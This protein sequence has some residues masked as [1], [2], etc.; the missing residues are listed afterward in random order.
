[1]LGRIVLASSLIVLLVS[2]AVSQKEARNDK[3]DQLF[4][5]WDKPMSPGCA[6]G[7]IRDGELIYERG[8][9]M[10]DLEHNI[11]LTSESVFYIASMSKQF[12]AA[13]IA[14]LAQ[15]GK[16]SLDDDIRKYLPEM[17]EYQRPVLIRNLI[18]HTSGIR[19]YIVLK[20][21]AAV[22][23][24]SVNSDDENYER[25]TLI[26]S[27]DV[28]KLIAR[29]R[30][31]SFLPGDESAYSNSN[32]FLLAQIVERVSGKTLPEFADENIFKPLG[33]F[34]THYY[35]DLFTVVENRSIGYSPSQSGAF[36]PVRLNNG[37]VGPAG[38]LTS[39]DDLL[40]WDRNFY[41]NKLG[42]RQ[43][44][45]DL[46]L[47]GDTLNDGTKLQYAFGLYNYKYKGLTAVGHDGG[48]FG[49]KTSM[50]RFTEQR[51]TVICLCNSRNAPMDV[52]A[53]QVTDIYLANEFKNSDTP[54]P[55][56]APENLIT[57]SDREL[58]NFSGIYWNPITEGLW[59]LRVK[60]GKLVDP[61]GGGSIL[62]PIGSNR[63]R[64]QGQSVELNFETVKP[65]ARPTR[66]V[67][68]T[69][70]G[71]PQEYSAVEPVT[72]SVEQLGE[73][74]GRYRS[75]ELDSTYTLGIQ[76]GK[77]VLLRDKANAIPFTP[78]F[79]DNFWSDEFG[80]LRF[81]RDKLRKVNGFLLTGGWI[82]RLSFARI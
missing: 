58:Q 59:M 3:V 14:L 26:T 79:V 20:Y 16:L 4:R 11:P 53:D 76:R 41:N 55:V 46:L 62:I 36:V 49:F 61:G 27:G 22:P 31:S 28:F 69:K 67:K 34:H 64:V 30:G 17:P 25:M 43:A 5:E 66:M 60:D 19:D 13:S 82:R 73:Y 63:F 1:M 35:E 57:L 42:V 44:F 68:I 8:Y 47:T 37:T 18:H 75:E 2:S 21:L 77:L 32:Y 80:Y 50:N 54:A 7:V 40:L 6:L 23:T 81:T 71:K 12:T 52:L 24:E 29:Q 72:P 51:F 10:A 56:S 70:S 48:F 65:G 39:V 45:I 15:Q 38:V 78:T 74:A 9:G 33:M